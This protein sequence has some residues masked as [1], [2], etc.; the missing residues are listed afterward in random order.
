MKVLMIATLCLVFSWLIALVFPNVWLTFLHGFL[1]IFLFMT[2]VYCY[3]KLDDI[4][5][6]D[7]SDFF[8]EIVKLKKEIKD[9]K[10]GYSKGV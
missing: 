3:Q 5:T 10:E 4:N 8:Y 1:I 6:F 7:H 9:L 2:I